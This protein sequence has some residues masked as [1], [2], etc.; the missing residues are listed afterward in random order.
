MLDLVEFF[1][2]MASSLRDKPQFVVDADAKVVE[3]EVSPS[4][5]GW[6]RLFGRMQGKHPFQRFRVWHLEEKNRILGVKAEGKEP[7][8]APFFERICDAYEIL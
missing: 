4:I 5:S 1:K 3:W 8:E 7:L 6:L 2:N